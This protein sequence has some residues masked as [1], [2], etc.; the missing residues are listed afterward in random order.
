MMPAW[1][2][3]P[4]PFRPRCRCPC[5][6]RL[7]TQ[8]ITGTVAQTISHLLFR[9]PPPRNTNT[10]LPARMRCCSGNDRPRKART[11]LRAALL[12]LISSYTRPCSINVRAFEVNKP[13]LLSSALTMLEQRCAWTCGAG[14][15]QS[16][17]TKDGTSSSWC[18]CSLARGMARDWVSDTWKL[19]LQD[20]Y[21]NVRHWHWLQQWCWIVQQTMAEQGDLQNMWK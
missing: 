18:D 10:V 19:I 8:R 9:R 11:C 6:S 2:P 20:M 17:S 21:L 14:G 1:N 12:T 4:R 16:P 5:S 15:L 13:R 7:Q 3:P